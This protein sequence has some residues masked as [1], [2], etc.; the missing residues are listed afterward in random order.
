MSGHV[1]GMG[2]A[3]ESRAMRLE[4]PLLIPENDSPEKGQRA[5]GEDTPTCTEYMKRKGIMISKIRP[6]GS[7]SSFR[8]SAPSSPIPH[9]G[10]SMYCIEYQQ[11]I[12][13]FEIIRSIHTP[14]RQDDM[15][16]SELSRTDAVQQAVPHHWRCGLLHPRLFQKVPVS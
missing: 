8:N 12:W 15:T 2:E 9:P 14:R 5:S 4:M 13:P 11:Q 1:L 3:D 7:A 16:R 10:K 6:Q